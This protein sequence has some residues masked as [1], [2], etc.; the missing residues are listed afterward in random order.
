M[1]NNCPVET[2]P[3][4]KN[5]LAIFCFLCVV[6]G[7]SLSKEKC[8]GTLWRLLFA[9]SLCSQDQEKWLRKLKFIEIYFGGKIGCVSWRVKPFLKLA[10]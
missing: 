7:N 9:N 10:L 2:A 1:V 3:P 6:N 5:K 8:E 4:Q